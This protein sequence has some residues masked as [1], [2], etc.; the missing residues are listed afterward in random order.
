MLLDVEMVYK[1]DIGRFI[2]MVA[3]HRV[4]DFCF[5]ATFTQAPA[6][7]LIR[8]LYRYNMIYRKSL[9]SDMSSLTLQVTYHSLS[10][11]EI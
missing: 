6:M 2:F 3:Y 4:C 11:E 5:K 8:P 9:M 7:R 10:Q 1:A